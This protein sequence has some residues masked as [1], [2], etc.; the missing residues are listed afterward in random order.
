MPPSTVSLK[1]TLTSKLTC[2]SFSQDL[3]LLNLRMKNFLKKIPFKN[4]MFSIYVCVVS[5]S[6][7][8]LPTWIP[9]IERSQNI[10]KA[11]SLIARSIATTTA[12]DFFNE[13]LINLSIAGIDIA[14][15]PEIQSVRFVGNDGD[16]LF[17]AGKPDPRTLYVSRVTVNNIKSGTVEISLNSE[18]FKPPRPIFELTLS[19]LIVCLMP[20]LLA[21]ITRNLNTEN[22]SIPI[23][24]V[25]NQPNSKAFYIVIN[26]INRLSMQKTLVEQALQDAETMSK[27]V[28]A[29]YEGSTI[30]VEELGICLALPNATCSAKQALSAVFLLQVLLGEYYTAG[31]FRC[32]LKEGAW[33]SKENDIEGSDFKSFF[34]IKDFSAWLTL[35]ALSQKD[36]ALVSS[37]MIPELPSEVRQHA[38]SF[39]HPLV[40]DI[41]TVEQIYVIEELPEVD[42]ELIN[43]QAKMILEFA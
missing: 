19:V 22:R 2:G 33:T 21:L 6:I 1:Q 10:E 13:E 8:F 14:K 37:V 18:A 43:Q 3:H 31:Q 35:A 12:N 25:K 41:D 24:S 7:A 40:R 11:G 36:T 16:V 28:A 23:I 42:E 38:K 26:L 4:R 34:S 39:E 17:S 5:C 15:H 32:F 20:M 30:R 27:E 29:L 9:Y